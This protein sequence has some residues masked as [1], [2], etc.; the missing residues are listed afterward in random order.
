MLLYRNLK[1]AIWLLAPYLL[2]TSTDSVAMAFTD[3]RTEYELG[4][5]AKQY[6]I[7]NF[8]PVQEQA[9]IQRVNHIIQRIVRV[10]DT[11]RGIEIEALVIEADQIGAWAFPGGFICLTKPLIDLCENDD[12]LAVI[13]GH[14]V[15]HEVK[16]HVDAPI[17][18]KVIDKYRDLLTE[19]TDSGKGFIAEYAAKDFTNEITRQKEFEADQYGILYAAMAGFDVSAAF[20]ILAK[21]MDEAERQKNLTQS[22][23]QERRMRIA[24][25]LKKILDM[26]EVFHAG[27]RFLQ[28]NEYPEALEAFRNFLAGARRCGGRF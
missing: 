28:R 6:I 15:A 8:R 10:A 24:Y 25:R 13:L 21:V 9:L 5:R 22:S 12:E 17:E 20:S 2:L 26:I 16:G 7:N 4:I 18:E 27:V 1:K 11:R 14:E 19:M 23:Y 3:S